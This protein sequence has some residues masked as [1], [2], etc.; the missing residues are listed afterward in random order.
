MQ[1]AEAKNNTPPPTRRAALAQIREEF[2]GGHTCKTATIFTPSGTLA[3]GSSV[4]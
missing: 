3:D 4:T 1:L 2:P